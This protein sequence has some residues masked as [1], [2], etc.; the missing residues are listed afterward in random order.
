MVA[1]ADEPPITPPRSSTASSPLYF[2]PCRFV[3]RFLWLAIVQR[4][5]LRRLELDQIYSRR[6]RSCR[7]R[8][9][10]NDENAWGRT[11]PACGASMRRGLGRTSHAARVRSFDYNA[12]M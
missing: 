10:K 12:S 9:M 5:N 1:P 2:L 3:L 6:S 4:Y 11:R 8:R 7:E